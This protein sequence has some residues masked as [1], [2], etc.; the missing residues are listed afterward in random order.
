M[1][2]SLASVTILLSAGAVSSQS[3]QWIEME[4]G[5]SAKLPTS[6][7]GQVGFHLLPPDE[8]GVTFTNVLS[9]GKASENQIRLNG[10]GVA[11]GDVDGDGWC[12][13]YLCRL[14][15]PNALYRNL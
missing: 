6:V 13:I 7:I 8:T 5:R 11:I 15:G 1:K 10:S 3:L 14:E 12:D 9:D 2:L 4:Y